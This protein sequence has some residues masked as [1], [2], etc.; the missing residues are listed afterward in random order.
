MTDPSFREL[1]YVKGAH[2]NPIACLEDVSL[3]LT[4]QTV[5]GY[6]HSIWQILGHVIYW[7]DYDLRRMDGE[8]P[9]Y[10][11]HNIQSWPISHGPSGELEWNEAVARFTSLL[12]KLEALSNSGPEVLNRQIEPTTPAHSSLTSTVHAM[13]WQTVVHNS[14]HIGQ[15]ALLRRCF[16]AWPPLRGGD[17]W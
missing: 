13:L 6:P 15:I 8:R 9:P 11:E 1:L 5:A 10:P 12:G 2:V 4:G 17:N 14:Y 7:M 16:G 3:A